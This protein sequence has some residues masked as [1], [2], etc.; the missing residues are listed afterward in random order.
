MVAYQGNS[1]P[2]LYANNSP[3]PA[4]NS[5]H[6]YHPQAG[7]MQNSHFDPSINKASAYAPSSASVPYNSSALSWQ[8]PARPIECGVQMGDIM[9]NGDAHEGTPTSTAMPFAQQDLGAGRSSA[10]PMLPPVTNS[11]SVD[12]V[13]PNMRGFEPTPVKSYQGQMGQGFR[14]PA[15]MG[16]P[17]QY[18]SQHQQPAPGQAP[19]EQWGVYGSAQSQQ[20]QHQQHSQPHSALPVPYAPQSYYPPA[21][22]GQQNGSGHFGQQSPS[23][24]QPHQHGMPSH[25]YIDSVPPGYAMATAPPGNA[26]SAS[27]AGG[28]PGRGYHSGYPDHSQLAHGSQQVSA[29]PN[30][31]PPQT[32][33]RP[34]FVNP[35]SYD[36]TAAA[37]AAAAAAASSGS[38]Y[39]QSMM[40]GRFNIAQ[41]GFS[42]PQRPMMQT[43]SRLGSSPSSS[44]QR[45]RYLC[46]VCSKLFARPST[47]ATHMHS[48]T[49]EKPYEC[50]YEGCGKRFSVM[51]NL[52]RHQR[53]H[54]RQRSKFSN[55]NSSNGLSETAASTPTRQDHESVNDNQGSSSV[56]SQDQQQSHL[57]GM[58][59]SA[60]P[61]ANE[62]SQHHSMD[63]ASLTTHHHLEA[64]A[65]HVTGDFA[66][67]SQPP[68]HS[69]PESMVVKA[70]IHQ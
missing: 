13:V 70:E 19:T 21:T 20:Q 61:S 31:N 55:P 9:G 16:S 45:K 11:V 30:G 43:M 49:G 58:S 24:Q 48:H 34:Y 41:P 27:H 17:H 33:P 60:P 46:H 8:E 65:S 44:S 6:Q 66:T 40:F 56:A 51:S 3:V 4:N 54:E 22:V 59:S 26:S 52:R 57:G 18:G 42:N 64:F 38:P 35:P 7:H 25:S 50:D 62:L 32:Y 53:I 2:P 23:S 10:T 39:Q 63:P 69:I 5:Q 36:P 37:A 28:A 29:D 67:Y 1:I 12:S 68:P 14:D 15:S 47:L